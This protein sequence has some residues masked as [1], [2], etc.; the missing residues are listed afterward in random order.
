M[1]MTKDYQKQI[2]YKK[3]PRIT[4]TSKNKYID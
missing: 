4:A 3:I 2:N 1:I